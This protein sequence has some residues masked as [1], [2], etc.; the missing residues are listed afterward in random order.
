MEG[1]F[2]KT[3]TNAILFS[4][5]ELDVISLASTENARRLLFAI[6][7]VAKS[8]GVKEVYFNSRSNVKLQDLCKF[9]RTNG[10]LSDQ[11]YIL[12]DLYKEN[13]IC[14]TDR[15]LCFRLPFLENGILNE[16]ELSIKPSDDM[17]ESY[18]KWF[19]ANYLFCQM[20]GRKIKRTN[21]RIKYCNECAV[22]K[23]KET[24]AVRKRHG[25][26]SKSNL[27]TNSR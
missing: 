27:L 17:V 1:L 11:E 19:N 22:K 15:L 16:V 10:R 26:G 18:E 4:R 5:R 7:C 13:L 25:A 2:N 3:N 14:A 24:S 12:H 21:N 9:A 20:C 6:C 23:N 8:R